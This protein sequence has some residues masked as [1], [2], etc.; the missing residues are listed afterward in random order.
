MAS[1]LLRLLVDL[2]TGHDARQAAALCRAAD[3]EPTTLADPDCRLPRSAALRLAHEL[4][5]RTPGE[6]F[7]LR[8]F[9][10]VHPGVF[11]L[12]GFAMMSSGTLRE[13]L[14]RLVR[15]A[16]LLD[17]SLVLTLQPEAD[18]WRLLRAGGSALP[19]LVAEAGMAALLGLC[20]FAAGG[21]GLPVL[22]AE[23]EVAAP[24]D[25]SAYRR[26]LP[27]A[28]LRFGQPAFSLLLQGTALDVP[29]PA[30]SP[31]LDRL[32]LDLAE[33]GL[34]SL[35]IHQLVSARVQQLIVAELRGRAPTLDAVA[36]A[37]QSSPRSLQRQLACEGRP[38]RQLLDDTR[39]QLAHQYLLHSPVTLKELAYLLGFGGLGSLHRACLRWFGMPPAR[40]RACRGAAAG[41]KPNKP[42]AGARFAPKAIKKGA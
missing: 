8:A 11:P 34:A 1:P 37:L 9:D 25:P 33:H 29:L 42:A 32:H 31:M 28:A 10:A 5:R 21:H 19:P 18:D 20:R 35:R 38:F 41:L 26:L 17:E 7:G 27:G 30:V 15:L 14:A 12:V 4:A 22:Q 23:F 16:P 40:Y 2:A 3:V 36:A 24:A 6:S 39:R 13:A